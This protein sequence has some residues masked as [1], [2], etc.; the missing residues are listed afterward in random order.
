MN[1][2]N[3]KEILYETRDLVLYY[4]KDDEDYKRSVALFNVGKIEK[5]L[6]HITNLEQV[7]KNQ[8]KRNSRQRLANQKQQELILKLQQEK[9]EIQKEIY[10]QIHTSIVQKK[11]IKNLQQEN[12]RLKENNQAMQEEMAR[13]WEKCDDYKSRCGKAIEYI[14]YNDSDL[15]T[16]EPDY[17]YEENLVD[18]YEPSSFREDLLNILQNGSNDND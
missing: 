9:E 2:E 6:D 16:F 5:I 3:I 8:A 13:T 11:Q 10:K 14:K 4:A 12:E 1:D 17:D 18:N 7:N 15:Y